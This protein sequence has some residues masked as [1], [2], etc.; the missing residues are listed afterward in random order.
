MRS[1]P[2][3]ARCQSDVCDLPRNMGACAARPE[4]RSPAETRRL[5]RRIGRCAEPGDLICLEGPLGVGK[6]VLVQG[7]AAGLGADQRATSP[8]FVIVH[9]YRGAAPLYH[10][11]LYRI[12]PEQ[13][14]DLALEHYLR[15][16]GVVVVE[17]AERLPAQ[18]QSDCLKAEISWGQGA[19]ERVICLSA[20]GKRSA[21]L[22]QRILRRRAR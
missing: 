9:E 7:L 19:S 1:S 18:F 12:E 8:S 20:T 3:A 15:G 21:R 4:S 11:D 14:S 16:Y 2:D 5:G 6:T 13:V 22:L 17:W 10:I